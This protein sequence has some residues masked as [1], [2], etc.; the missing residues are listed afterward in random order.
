MNK[1]IIAAIGTLICLYPISVSYG[2]EITDELIITGLGG[3]DPIVLQNSLDYIK[4]NTP[5]VLLP[6]L[7][8]LLTS[9]GNNAIHKNAMQ[10]LQYYPLYTSLNHWISIL[11]DTPSFLIKKD[12]ISFL[13]Q[14]GNKEI[15]P[16]LMEQLKSPFYAVREEATLAL[17][18]FRDDRVYAYILNMASGDNPVFKV[19]SLEAIYHLYDS[20]LYNFLIGMLGDDNK[21]VRYY[22][23]NCLEKNE[24]RKSVNHISKTALSD[25]NTEVRVKALDILSNYRQHNS[26]SVFLRCIDDPDRDIRFASI[27]AINRGKHRNTAGVLSRQLYN[28][29]EKDIKTLIMGTL[30]DFR[31]GGGFYGLEKILLKD[32]GPELRIKAA[33]S[34]GQ[35]K[36]SKGV[37]LL[38]EGLNDSNV[39]V[40]AEAS[41]A[42]QYF[43]ETRVLDSLL[44]VLRREESLYLRTAALY[45]INRLKLKN[46]VLPLFNIYTAE[47]DIVFKDILR[48][49]HTAINYSF[50]LIF[51]RSR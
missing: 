12:V 13:S 8:D 30:V 31:D 32:P 17:K 7:E 51:I 26:L 46:S 19:Y 48:K 18:K 2:Q 45:S 40:K 6:K 41:N 24:L 23:L 21:S 35:I 15:V 5:A 47:N 33:F 36:N 39:K 28:E 44:D 34:I 43:R 49:S 42:L 37:P 1:L 20:R 22:V 10:A 50:Y 14:S 29:S 16:P 11:N 27:N 9:R 25:E 4:K 38:I 3:S